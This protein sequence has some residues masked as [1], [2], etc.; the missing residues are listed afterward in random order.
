MQDFAKVFGLDFN[1]AKTGSVYLPGSAKRDATIAKTLPAGPVKIGFLNLDPET[2]KW[3]IDQQLVLAH[4]DQLKK[5]LAE[6]KSVLSWVQTWNSCIG[7]FFS[8]T[9]GEPARC[10]GREH[11]EEVLSTYQNMLQR[12][13]P[14]SDGKEGSVIEHRKFQRLP[15]APALDRTN[16]AVALPV[17]RMI[18]DRFGVSDL[19]DSFVHLPEQLGGLGLRNPFVGL[20]LVRNKITETPEELIDEFLKNERDE[21][22]EAKRKFDAQGET[23]LRRRL[24]YIYS[25][26]ESARKGAVS[27]SELTT[28]FSLDEFSRLRERLSSS[29]F[30][31]FDLLLDVPGAETIVLSKE[32]DGALRAFFAGNNPLDPEKKWFLQLYAKE[33]LEDFGGLSLVDK[34]FLPVGVLAMLRG[35]KVS[36]NMIL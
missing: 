35:K 28:F 11:V 21:Y 15:P 16:Q 20:F 8:H 24:R 4:V 12:L 22:L 6:C 13:F 31:T 3:V 36:W 32:V 29:F 26:T 5:Q 2:G 17:K 23:E 1:K 7:R 30:D 9:F 27:E 18:E 25:D 10:F 19:P 34:Q 14:S 33:L